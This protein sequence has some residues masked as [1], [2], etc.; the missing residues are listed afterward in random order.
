MAK[1]FDDIYFDIANADSLVW[2]RH[3][4]ISVVE[5]KLFTTTI[6]PFWFVK[7]SVIVF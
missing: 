4:L 5:K 2:D 7:I 3:C 1:D 6:P